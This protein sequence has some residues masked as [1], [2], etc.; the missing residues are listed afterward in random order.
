V[1]IGFILVYSRLSNAS[2]EDSLKMILS[3]VLPPTVNLIEMQT[4]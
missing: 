3:A 2:D 1:H 4:H